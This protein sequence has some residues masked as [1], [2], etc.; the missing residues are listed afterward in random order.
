MGLSRAFEWLPPRGQFAERPCVDVVGAE[1]RKGARDFGAMRERP[2]CV[3]SRR[4]RIRG[5]VRSGSP[6]TR[7]C[8]PG[9]NP[10]T[11]RNN[12]AFRFSSRPPESQY[13]TQ[14]PRRACGGFL[15]SLPFKLRGSWRLPWG[16]YLPLNASAF[17]GRTNSLAP[18]SSPLSPTKPAPFSR[19][20][21]LQRD[22]AADNR[23]AAA[24]STEPCS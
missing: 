8:E 17:A 22:T 4:A 3:A 5:R 19:H 10:S 6:G 24:E 11:L 23:T 14:P 7:I 12:A 15:S 16:Y 2:S 9:P 18:Y 20:H 21:T 13:V 1:G